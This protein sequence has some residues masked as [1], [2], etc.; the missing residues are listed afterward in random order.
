[1]YALDVDF[2]MYGKDL[3]ESAI[4]S[5]KIIKLLGKNNP[6]GF[7]YELFLD[8]EKEFRKE[9]YPPYK[10]LCRILFAHKNANIAN[11]KMLQMQME[12]L[13]FEDIEIVGSGKAPIERVA[14]KFRFNI[15]II[16]FYLTE[17]E[18]NL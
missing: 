13:K 8:D 7:A 6:S 16:C 4:L 10:K 11:Q 3:I 12:L 15:F 9:L 18:S 17:I 1:M 14:N 5:T 2:E